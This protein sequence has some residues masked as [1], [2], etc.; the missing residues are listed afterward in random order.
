MQ[1]CN[2]GVGADRVVTK[3][4]YVLLNCRESA[5]LASGCRGHL[6]ILVLETLGMTSSPFPPEV[7]QCSQIEANLILSELQGPTKARAHRNEFESTRFVRH[8]LIV[9]HAHNET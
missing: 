1:L 9:V 8:D 6:L 2:Y 7:L 3:C 5:L 4:Y